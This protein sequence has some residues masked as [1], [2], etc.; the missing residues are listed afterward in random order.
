MDSDMVWTDLEEKPSAA[1]E[2]S[3]VNGRSR[4]AIEQNRSRARDS[5]Q[6]AVVD[7]VA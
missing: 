1:P 5:T 6:R 7:A 3:Q 4:S 2:K